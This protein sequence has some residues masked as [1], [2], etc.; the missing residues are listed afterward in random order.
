VRREI[1]M[2]VTKNCTC[3]TATCNTENENQPLRETLQFYPKT[4]AAY[5]TE[6]SIPVY[7]TI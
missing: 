2:S 5:T 3:D 7:Q 1:S 4:E 6:T